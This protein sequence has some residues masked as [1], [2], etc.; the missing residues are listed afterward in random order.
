MDRGRNIG[1]PP[2]DAERPQESGAA[3]P[4]VQTISATFP[5]AGGVSSRIG[6]CSSSLS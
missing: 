3:A 5:G 2:G 1:A 6:A 4:M